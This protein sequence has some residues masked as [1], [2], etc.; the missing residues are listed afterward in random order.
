VEAAYASMIDRLLEIP[1]SIDPITNELDPALLKLSKPAK[2]LWIDFHDQ[3]AAEQAGMEGELSAAWSKLTGA[4]LRLALVVELCD[5]ASGIEWPPRSYIGPDAMGAGIT[6]ANW[7]SA[8][9]RRVYSVLS[10]TDVQ[11]EVRL[12]VEM[13]ERNGG[14]IT[15]RELCR[16]SRRYS[17]AEPAELALIRLVEIGVA[18]WQPVSS[19]ESGGHAGWQLVLKHLPRVDTRLA[20]PW[21][22]ERVA[23]VNTNGE[24]EIGSGEGDENEIIE[25]T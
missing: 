18:E 19:P 8:E 2:A 9:A 20:R 1:L 14:T 15:T 4:A 16:S 6:L 10:E 11:R 13:I 7:F 17:V 21:G 3:H 5:W 23:T 24:R 12:L 22:N 25:W